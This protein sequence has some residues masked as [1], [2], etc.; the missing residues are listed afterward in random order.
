MVKDLC[1]RIWTT[2][3]RDGG[4]NFTSPSGP[5][6]FGAVV[7][8]VAAPGASRE[9]AGLANLS[10]DRSFFRARDLRWLGQCHGTVR[11]HVTSAPGR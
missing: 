7:E 6:W 11:L 5:V 10:G 4:R 8:T 3:P 1:W 9:A 2:Q